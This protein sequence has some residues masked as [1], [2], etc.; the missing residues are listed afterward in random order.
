MCSRLVAHSNG[1]EIHVMYLLGGC[2]GS[3]G[4]KPRIHD[5]W[6]NMVERLPVKS[7]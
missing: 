5:I 7:L 4:Y 6:Y 3:R 2:F 1:I